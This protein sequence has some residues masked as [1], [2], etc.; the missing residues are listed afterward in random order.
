MIGTGVRLII[1]NFFSQNNPQLSCVSWT[2]VLLTR[3]FL[4]RDRKYHNTFILPHQTAS[5]WV[6]DWQ[7]STTRCFRV[8]K[9]LTNVASNINTTVPWALLSPF[10]WNENGRKANLACW[11]SYVF[12]LWGQIWS[13][14][15]L[16]DLMSGESLQWNCCHKHQVCS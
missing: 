4:A 8:F 6:A 15:F 2:F 1:T 7:P 16:Q 13:H 12:V 11:S 14:E 9:Q 5:S 10:Y 3:S